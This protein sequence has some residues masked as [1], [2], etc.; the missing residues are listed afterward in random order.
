MN[1]LTIALVATGLLS[2]AGSAQA[3]VLLYG[4]NGSDEGWTVTVDS[5]TN[6]GSIIGTT[7]VRGITEGTGALEAQGTVTADGK[8]S[9]RLISPVETDSILQ[10][11]AGRTQLVVDAVMVSENF[12]GF[13]NFNF[14][15]TILGKDADGNN[16]TTNATVVEHVG[17]FDPSRINSN[18]GTYT[19]DYSTIAGGSLTAGT[20]QSVQFRFNFSLAGGLNLNTSPAANDVAI[21]NFRVVPEPASF[22]TIGLGGL[23]LM[24]RRRRSA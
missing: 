11:L 4:W 1:R 12:T 14:S 2:L 24:A 16:F 18:P 19:Y 3:S 9:F 20:A 22:A 5:Q 6:G 17:G 21:D 8:A 7:P 13:A 15:L 23:M 10:Q